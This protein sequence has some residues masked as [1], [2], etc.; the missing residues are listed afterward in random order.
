LNILKT[1]TAANYYWN[2]EDYNA[3]KTIWKL[4][5]KYYGQENAKNLVYFNDAYFGLKEFT[6]KIKNNGVNNKNSRVV[7]QFL[8]DL[9]YYS[10]LLEQQ[11]ADKELLD[12]L[13]QLKNELVN[14][15]QS[16]LSTQNY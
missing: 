8:Q 5:V 13:I 14:D 16:I 6:Q 10:G 1:L 12:E 15:Y 9:N 2:T 11:L 3:D 4:L 7:N